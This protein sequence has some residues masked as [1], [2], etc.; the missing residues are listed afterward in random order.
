MTFYQLILTAIS[1]WCF[2][3]PSFALSA[4]FNFHGE[5]EG[6]TGIVCILASMLCMLLALCLGFAGTVTLGFAV[7]SI[8]S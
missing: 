8:L 6:W 5:M 1:C 3:A 4:A 7:V 2:V